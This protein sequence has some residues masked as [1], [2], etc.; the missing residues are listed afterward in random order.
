[1]SP[2]ITGAFF[3]RRMKKDTH[4]LNY[5]MNHISEHRKMRFQEIISFRTRHIALVVENVFQPHNASAVLRSCDCFGIQDVHIIE[6][7]NT[8]E[9][10]PNIALGASKWLSLKK[11]NQK[12]FNTPDCLASLKKQGYKLVATSPHNYDYTIHDLPIDQKMAVMMGTEL[13]GLTDEA[14]AMAD[15]VV[16]IPMFGFTESFNIS[17]SAALIMF[18]L[19]RRLHDSD[20]QWHL[21]E[22]EKTAVLLDWARSSIKKHQMLEQRFY[23]NN[24]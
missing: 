2:G 14:F 3:S 15:T 16:N 22:E 6:N 18:E 7:Y 10:N 23:E 9:V 24:A 11:Y 19:T 1:M 17:V 8:Y 20:I 13:Q 5:L 12:D 4:L 21:S